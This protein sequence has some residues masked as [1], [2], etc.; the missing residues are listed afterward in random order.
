MM[1]NQANKKMETYLRVRLL[2]T[3]KLS[4]FFQRLYR[5]GWTP[6]HY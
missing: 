2:L 3:L 1:E 4:I 6:T 5:L